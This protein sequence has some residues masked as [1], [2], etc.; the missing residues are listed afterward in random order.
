MCNYFAYGSNMD[1]GSLN[2]WCLSKG[3][4]NVTFL[5]VEPA[6]LESYRLEF[7]HFSITRNA[8]AANI[9]ESSGCA[10]YGLLIR[11]SLDDL[12]KIRRKEGFPDYYDEIR[13]TVRILSNNQLTNNVRTYKIVTGKEHTEFQPPTREYLNLIV[14][15][16]EEHNFPEDY[17]EHLRSIQTVD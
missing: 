16:A 15:C 1:L 3:L 5:S 13:V 10:V 8:G 6:R 7:N 17:I 12:Q 4:G 9:M 11:V 2:G 14:R